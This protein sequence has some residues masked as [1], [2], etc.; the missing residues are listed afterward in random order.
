MNELAQ[1]IGFPM[2]I[3]MIIEC[4]NELFLLLLIV[5]MQVGKY[6][7]NSNELVS[8]VKIPLTGE[9]VI[10]YSAIFVYNLANI[11]TL[12]YGGHNSPSAYYVMRIGVFCYYL[13]GA[14]QTVFFLDIIKSYIA[15][16]NKDKGLER[17][18]IGFQL[19]EVPNVL[20]LLATPFTNALYFIDT[21]NEYNRSW[22]YYVWQG[23]TIVT[24]L[25]IGVVA[26]LYRKRTDRFIKSIIAITVNHLT[27]K[28]VLTHYFSDYGN[29]SS[30]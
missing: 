16:K 14:F 25:F 1:R 23:I 20:L 24:F 2:L 29:A 13:V 21:A 22:G 6:R 28:Q 15:R 18:I 5:V 4:W 30:A 17:I 9:L 11:I 26:V 3:Q 8:K 10:F 12:I 27:P 19:L 7:D